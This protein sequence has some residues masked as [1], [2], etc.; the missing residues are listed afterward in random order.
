MIAMGRLDAMLDRMMLERDVPVFKK[1]QTGK[2]V[3][4]D[5]A[6]KCYSAAEIADF[7]GVHADCIRK[8]EYSALEKI[9][10]IAAENSKEEGIRVSN[11]FQK[12]HIEH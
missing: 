11:F 3:R 1:V 2:F 4:C 9:R 12:K 10:K 6:R 5:T 8:I 7:C